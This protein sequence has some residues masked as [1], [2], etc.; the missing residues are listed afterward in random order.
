MRGEYRRGPGHT[1]INQE[2]AALIIYISVSI[3]RRAKGKTG[4]GIQILGEMLGN[5]L[6][7]EGI[8]PKGG[9]KCEMDVVQHHQRAETVHGKT[10][11][12]TDCIEQMCPVLG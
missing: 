10:T 2:D 7:F 4:G 5:N 8:Y 11:Q 1:H 9:E 3:S 12:R 6:G